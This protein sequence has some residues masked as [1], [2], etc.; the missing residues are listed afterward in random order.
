MTP[1]PPIAG[2]APAPPPPGVAAD[3]YGGYGG[4]TEVSAG[5]VTLELSVYPREQY[6]GEMAQVWATVSHPENV[7]ITSL[8]LDYGNGQVVSGGLANGWYC[9][10]AQNASVGNNGYVYPAPGSFRITATVTFV[11]CIG[12]P[13]AYIGPPQPPP[14]GLVGPWFPEPHQSLSAAIPVLQRPDRPPPPVG[15]P[16]GP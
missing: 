2:Y 4:F 12:I 1:S 9:N 16:P 7:A 6:F 8:K 13:G 14:T 10:T 3:G 15:P 11:T 5:P